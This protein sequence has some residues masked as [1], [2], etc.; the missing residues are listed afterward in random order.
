MF[1]IY[2]KD[3]GMAKLG[4]VDE[5]QFNNELVN[6]N[7]KREY[8]PFDATVIDKPARGRGIGNNEVPDGLR[9]IIGEESVINGRDKALELAA[10]FGIS[11]SAVSAYTK[12]ATST[13]SINRPEITLQNYL[14]ARKNRA[15]KKALRNLNN[16]LDHITD[17]KL[18]DIKAKDLA[19]IA[20]DMSVVAKNME[21]DNKDQGGS[22]TPKFVVYA[23]TIRDE[24][25][26]ETI[27]VSDN[28]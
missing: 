22:N 3:M 25:T 11:P 7:A 27:V 17:D 10:D 15:S 16:A 18:S 1:L 8:K 5:E 20:K 4:I 28:Y 23:P 13:A 12:G 24:R 6:T 2:R 26:Y 14:T 9:K 21:P 19:S